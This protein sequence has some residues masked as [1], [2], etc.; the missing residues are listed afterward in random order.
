M[1]E[2]VLPEGV[3]I[4]RVGDINKLL[5]R[6]KSLDPGKYTH[7]LTDGSILIIDKDN[8]E[9]K[10]GEEYRAVGTQPEIHDEEV[11]EIIC[12]AGTMLVRVGGELVGKTAALN[13]NGTER[14]G[15]WVGTGIKGGTLF[16]LTPGDSMRVPTG[17]PHLHTPLPDSGFN[18]AAAK[19]TK[20]PKKPR[21]PRAKAA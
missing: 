17:K 12:I 19:F 2:R 21:F 7:R 8:I 13:E 3:E 15:E 18:I 1:S 4:F 10:V 9:Q 6:A 11:D 14:P 20:A 16:V 5:E